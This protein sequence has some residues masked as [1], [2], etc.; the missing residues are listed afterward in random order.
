MKKNGKKTLA[1]RV[2]HYF[3]VDASEFRRP[4]MLCF[5]A[6]FPYSKI[7]TVFRCVP[8]KVMNSV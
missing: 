4:E 2:R 7:K 8:Q 6:I 5:V 3:I 1:I